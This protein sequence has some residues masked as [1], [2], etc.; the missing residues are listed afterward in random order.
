M[1]IVI[2]E[3]LEVLKNNFKE[4]AQWI[5]PLCRYNKIE[6]FVII[7]DKDLVFKAGK[8]HLTLFTKEH[9][10]HIKAKLPLIAHRAGKK[11]GKLI[12]PDAPQERF[13]EMD[14][15]YL[16]C[17]GRCR[18]PRA[19]E[20]WTRGNDLPDGSYCKETWDRILNAIVAYELVKVI[21]PKDKGAYIG[22]DGMLQPSNDSNEEKNSVNN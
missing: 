13:K 17:T 1:S 4:L 2:N 14:R 12:D 15:G 19:G 8:I 9:S 20:D 3:P 5:E 7:D 6:D 22:K 21:K 18:K 10:Y 11:I 16:C